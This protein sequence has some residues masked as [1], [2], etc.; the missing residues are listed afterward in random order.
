MGSGGYVV[1]PARLEWPVDETRPG[2]LKGA[3]VE[4][5]RGGWRQHVAS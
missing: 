2:E 5:E 3:G 4:E 1:E